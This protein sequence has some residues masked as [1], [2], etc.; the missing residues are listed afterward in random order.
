M[1]R[2][3]IY[4]FI[5]IILILLLAN[6]IALF[7]LFNGKNSNS[8]NENV[9]IINKE[10]EAT[11]AIKTKYTKLFYPK[12]WE[13]DVEIKIYDDEVYT[14][15]FSTDNIPLFDIYFN[16]QGDYVLGTLKHESENILVS[17]KNYPI[18]NK[19]EK[20]QKYIKMQEDA[21]VLIQRLTENENFILGETI[22]GN[23]ENVYK[24][25]NGF[26][27]IYYPKRWK[28][29][30]VIDE[31]ED[32]IVFMYKDNKLF[33]LSFGKEEGFFLG[34]YRDM[35]VCILTYDLGMSNFSDE[36]LEIAEAMQ[37]DM[38]VIIEKMKENSNFQAFQ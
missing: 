30:I 13:K 33:E 14:V 27:E 5:G 32:S 17:I 22:D 1:K 26:M 3:G 37:E 12:I 20:E 19:E 29:K 18:E 15:K 38:N 28:E 6:V 23:L 10:K 8:E 34:T 7:F 21:N 25:D 16:E 24:I 35:D 31:T 9:N 2:K 11:F 36:E 4:G